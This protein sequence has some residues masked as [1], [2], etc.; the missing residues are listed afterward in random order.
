M[1]SSRGPPIAVPER[2][3]SRATRIDHPVRRIE[4]APRK[5]SGFNIC[6]PIRLQ[7]KFD[8][9]WLTFP[10]SPPPGDKRARPSLLGRIRSFTLRTIE[11]LLITDPQLGRA[12]ACGQLPRANSGF[13]RP[14][15]RSIEELVY[16]AP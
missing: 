7:R 10:R 2:A 6:M 1:P 12:T 3:M 4:I 5:R 11:A 15:R 8:Q 9:P 13:D 14:P 16:G